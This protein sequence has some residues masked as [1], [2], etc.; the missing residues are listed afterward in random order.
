[1]DQ[2]R[3][4]ELCE[5]LQQHEVRLP[6]GDRLSPRRLQLLGIS[7]GFADA[8]EDIHFLLEEA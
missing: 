6:N 2:Q 4:A 3:L 8:A 5:H 1:M 7:L